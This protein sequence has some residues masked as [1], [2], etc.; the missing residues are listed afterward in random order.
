MAMK[1]GVPGSIRRKLIRASGYMCAKCGAIGKEIRWPSGAFT[2]PTDIEGVYLSIDH[3][4]PRSKGGP[5][6]EL[7]NL[8]VL[9][10][11]CNTKKGSRVE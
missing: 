3:I 6:Q 9:C 4:V 11:R 5:E 2:F 7:S 1:S 8:R 10:T